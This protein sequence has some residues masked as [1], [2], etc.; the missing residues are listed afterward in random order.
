MRKPSLFSYRHNG[1]APFAPIKPAPV[2]ADVHHLPC[3]C[4]GIA[5]GACPVRA[6]KTAPVCGR[7]SSALFLCRRGRARTFKPLPS[8]T[9]AHGTP[10]ARCI[11]SLMRDKNK[12]TSKSPRKHR[13]HP[14]FRAR[15]F[16]RLASCSPR[17]RPQPDAVVSAVLACA[18]S[19]SAQE[20]SGFRKDHTTWAGAQSDAKG[21]Y[22][23]P[24]AS[25]SVVVRRRP[26]PHASPALERALCTRRALA[27]RACALGTFL[28]ATLP[29]PP[30]PAPRLMTIASRP[31]VSGA[32]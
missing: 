26:R 32:G 4:G 20:Q 1:P 9:R 17:Q 3:F 8:L 19:G 25:R 22:L 7:A 12:R 18:R 23:H 16:F 31:S 10:D 6:H 5:R 30:H 24:A 11:R 28:G 21:A 14:A 29:R 13:T 27:H 15:W 2:P